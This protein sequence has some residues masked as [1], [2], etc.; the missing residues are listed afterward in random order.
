MYLLIVEALLWIV[1]LSCE[2]ILSC[3][4]FT[5][6]GPQKRS[7]QQ[8]HN[9][10]KAK[11]P[12]NQSHCQG[13]NVPQQAMYCQQQLFDLSVHSQKHIGSSSGTV[14][15]LESSETWLGVQGKRIM[16]D[17]TAFYSGSL[18]VNDK[19]KTKALDKG[20]APAFPPSAVSYL[21]PS[22]DTNRPV[23]NAKY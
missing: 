1:R 6:A 15:M 11:R 8:D 10:L 12:T 18:V 3:H 5:Y 17:C 20:K 2:D 9:K 23:I 7:I 4:Y 16:Q 14:R 19:A 22:V 21:H 13:V